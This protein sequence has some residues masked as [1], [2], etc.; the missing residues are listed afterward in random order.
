[1]GTAGAKAIDG[2]EMPPHLW[3]LDVLQTSSEG[4]AAPAQR[5]ETSPANWSLAD[6]AQA[7]GYGAGT[8]VLDAAFGAATVINDSAIVAGNLLTGRQF[9]DTAFV[10]DAIGRNAATGQ[11]LLNAAAQLVS[12]NPLETL[13][14]Y[15]DRVE[16]KWLEADVLEAQGLRWE[17]GVM[18]GEIGA[19]LSAWAAGGGT[20]AWKAMRRGQDAAA[21]APPT[22][23]SERRTEEALFTDRELE[24]FWERGRERHR[25]DEAANAARWASMQEEIAADPDWR[26]KLQD[27]ID[28]QYRRDE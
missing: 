2:A 4:A 13:G 15:I 8:S 11:G 6:E 14:A 17:A 12:R 22:N 21:T 10:G 25:A 18:R 28:S 27:H 3:D 16:D 26:Q 20:L 23:A 1:M 19:E 24:E 9:E 7:W 5:S